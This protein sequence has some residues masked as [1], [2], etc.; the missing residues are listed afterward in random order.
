MGNF[1]DDSAGNNKIP[2]IK[3]AE[4]VSVTDVTKSGRIRV[5]ITGVDDT[6][7][8][9]SK[10]PLCAP[11]LPKY[12]L[13]LPKVGECVFI[14]QHEYNESSPTASFKSNRYWVGPLITQPDKLNEEPYNNALS[15]LPDGYVKLKDPKLEKGTYGENEDIILQGRYNTDIIQKDREIWIRA[16]KTV[17]GNPKKF[18]KDLAYIQ[19]KYGGSKL[20]RVVDEETIETLILPIPDRLIEVRM[21]TITNENRILVGDL[22]KDTYRGS[23]IN[24][25][26]LYITVYDMKTGDVLYAY[27]NEI[28]FNGAQSRDN[29]FSAA[30]KFIK[31]YRGE[32]W[33]IKSADNSCSDFISDV[34]KGKSGIAVFSSTPIPGP[35]KIIQK[36]RFEK[37][38]EETGTVI[39]VV[40]NKINLLSNIKGANKFNLSDPKS[41]ITDKEQENIN[42]ESH[43][44]VYGD[45]L[46]DFLELVKTYVKLH[47]HPYHGLP[48]DIG[49]VADKVLDF[50]LETILNMNI[51]SN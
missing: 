3:V 50:P 23:N 26:E 46:V 36:I 4:V 17:D 30:E 24:R 5:R 49:T 20:K 40:A 19:L 51:N 45:T 32:K 18:N 2:L 37:N 43:P 39:N 48:P 16:G 28:S 29:A 12:L 22:P 44:L 8:N 47:V 38:D 15:I 35:S 11:L 13:T 31:T 33:K 9:D 41:L 14:F 1:Y 6:I 42:S 7:I 10:L 34:Y 21:N 25:T 27:E